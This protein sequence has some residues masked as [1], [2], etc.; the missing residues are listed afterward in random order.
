MQSAGSVKPTALPSTF[1]TNLSP[2]SYQCQ[3]GVGRKDSQERAPRRRNWGWRQN[4][5]LVIGEGRWGGYCL[6]WL[7]LRGAATW[8][9][10]F[11]GPWRPSASLLTDF[12]MQHL[13]W[14]VLS[15]LLWLW[16][17][18][19]PSSL[20]T[21]VSSLEKP[22]HIHLPEGPSTLPIF[23]RLATGYFFPPL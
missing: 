19:F 20:S 9:A 11:R 10:F 22:L 21:N 23:L 3:N 7:C 15:F 17:L 8:P 2:L 4:S 16:L 1:Q 12:V 5:P 14:N 18:D 13:C 6:K